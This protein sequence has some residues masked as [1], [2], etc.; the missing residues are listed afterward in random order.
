MK[1]CG[2]DILR[3]TTM[4]ECSVCVV[5]QHNNGGSVKPGYLW[6]RN[7]DWDFCY[8]CEGTGLDPISD[9]Q[10]IINGR[11]RQIEDLSREELISELI[12]AIDKLE[13]IDILQEQLNDKIQEWRKRK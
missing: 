4:N 10:V 6:G 5:G 11:V 7:E 13:E 12:L 3:M 8:Y 1:C 9:Y 2:W